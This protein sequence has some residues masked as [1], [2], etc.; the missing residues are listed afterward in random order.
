[1]IEG[2]FGAGRTAL[3][4]TLAEIAEGR[5][6]TVCTARCSTLERELPFAAVHQL[7]EAPLRAMAAQDP[8]PR[9]RTAAAGLLRELEQGVAPAYHPAAGPHPDPADPADPVDQ[10]AVSQR[11]LTGVL[12]AVRRLAE[13]GPVVLAVDDLNFCDGASLRTLA[14]AIRRLRR[15]PVLIAVTRRT[16]EPV[17]EPLMAEAL[18]DAAEWTPVVPLSPLTPQGVCEVADRLGCPLPAATAEH[19][20]ALTGGNPMLVHAILAGS[21]QVAR[22]FGPTGPVSP[23]LDRLLAGAVRARLAHLP[24]SVLRVAETVA[25][26]GRCVGRDVLAVAA[27][28]SEHACDAA[29]DLLIG[30]GLLVAGER[31]GFAHPIV[32]RA[33]SRLAETRD[34]EAVHALIAEHLYHRHA[35]PAQIADHLMLTRPKGLAWAAEVLCAAADAAVAARKPEKAGTVL[36]RALGEPLDDEVRARVQARLDQIELAIAPADLARHLRVRL[37]IAQ[38]AHRRATA[39]LT[40]A[41]ALAREGKSDEAV[42]ALVEQRKRLADAAGGPEIEQ[43][44]RLLAEAEAQLDWLGSAG[45][46]LHERGAD[47]AESEDVAGTLAATVGRLLPGIASGTVPARSLVR[48]LRRLTVHQHARWYEWSSLA[49]LLYAQLWAG[50]P[51]LVDR[52]CTT[53]LAEP[54]TASTLLRS[55][56]A[57]AVRAAARLELGRL[58]DAARDA[59][60]ALALLGSGRSTDPLR[61]LALAPLLSALAELDQ[62]REA[63]RLLGDHAAVACP[64]PDTWPHDVLLAARA[65]ARLAGGETTEA[66]ADL[67]EAGR[68]LEA[69]GIGNPAIVPWRSATAVAHGRNGGCEDGWLLAQR[70]L[71]LAKTW[72]Q[73]RAL[74]FALRARGMNA[75]GAEGLTDLARSVELLAGGPARLELAHAQA[76]LG[77]AQRRRG[78]LR[79]ARETLR[80]AQRLAQQLGACALAARVREELLSAGALPR[81]DAQFGVASRTGSERRVAA[82]AATG[83]SNGAIAREL[84]VTR[85]TVETH[86]THTYRKLGI[87]SR[88]ELGRLLQA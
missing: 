11:V 7:L 14:F 32:E 3:L 40:Y 73:Q 48:R 85:R 88:S 16:G 21:Q 87:R 65:K 69:R 64:L 26:A 5:R 60:W 75:P 29:L 27:D 63:L 55:I 47:P 49:L 4:L 28:V 20:H 31:L 82:L 43:A 37:T 38:P 8:D 12:W 62:G 54:P 51:E 2:G 52:W 19:V 6:F 10:A 74:A 36:L 79:A 39:V 34:P 71:E 45:P 77:S 1:M 35:E 81:R 72:G 76:E 24:P 70:E 57:S 50:E 33:L 23:E 46:R 30:M 59:R 42:A 41:H 18:A 66:L 44:A 22:D 67:A 9:A 17:A 15:V 53:L 80:Q 78:M 56:T 61:A 58:E 68:R 83:W 25:L 86:L 84:F 13:R